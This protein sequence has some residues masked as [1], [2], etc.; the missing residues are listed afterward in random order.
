MLKALKDRISDMFKVGG[1][2]KIVHS[3]TPG[4]MKTPC[5]THNFSPDLLAFPRVSLLR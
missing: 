4:L 1:H 5:L 3:R 2:L